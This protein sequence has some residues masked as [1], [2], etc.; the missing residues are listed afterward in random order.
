MRELIR[1]KF[2][3][4]TR[5]NVVIEDLILFSNDNDDYLFYNTS[6]LLFVS[7]NKRRVIK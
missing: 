2:K 5:K 4:Y 3:F 1:I 7:R 6:S